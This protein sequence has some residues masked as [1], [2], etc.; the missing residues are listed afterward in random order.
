MSTM[1]TPAER[2]QFDSLLDGIIAELPRKYHELLEEI[3]LV[4]EDRPSPQLLDE[5]EIDAKVSDLCGLHTGI[6]LTR[7]SV[8][9]SGVL[10]DNIM[11]FREPIIR[12][13]RVPSR[14]RGRFGAAR[15]RA[16]RSVREALEYEIRVTLLHEMGHHFGLGEE[17]LAD[18]G[19]A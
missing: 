4:V 16:K 7:R 1:L 15:E 2:R 17:E 11:L 3:P 19:Y 14:I 5:L 12:L 9:H 18:L 6:P 13:A 10:P 8:E